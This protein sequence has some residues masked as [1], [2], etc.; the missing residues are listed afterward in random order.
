M[1]PYVCIIYFVVLFFSFSYYVI[2]VQTNET[3]LYIYIY[4]SI[5]NY[6]S[7]FDSTTTL[8]LQLLLYYSNY[9]LLYYYY[10]KLYYYLLLLYILLYS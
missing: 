8:L 5:A 10:S 9:V 1:E 7:N 4:S 2:Y 3:S 6:S